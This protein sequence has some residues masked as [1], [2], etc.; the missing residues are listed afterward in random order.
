MSDIEAS[1][2]MEKWQPAVSRPTV[3]YELP[4]N[5]TLPAEEETPIRLAEEGQH[6]AQGGTLTVS[7]ALSIATFHLLNRPSTL[8]TLR[9]ELFGAIA[10]PD[11]AV[12]LA[13][14]ENLPYLRAVVKE[15]LRLAIGTSKLA[16]ISTDEAP[17]CRDPEA[18]QEWNRKSGTVV[19][20]S[21]Y[22]TVMDNS[23]FPDP[24]GFRPERWLADGAEDLDKYLVVFG[25]GSRH[26][27]DQFLAYAELYLM[28]AK[29]F[30]R[31]GSAGVVGGSDEGDRR[32]GDVGVFKI[33]ETTTTDCETASDYFIPTPYKV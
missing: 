30:R 7:W 20:M 29:L 2:D 23:I 13:Q 19:S 11:E 16:R 18:G 6:P 26:G 9:D 15:S 4:S 27:L 24:K 21:P 12:S 31:W 28:L 33:Y 5:K 22:L 32:S 25:S 14:L 8:Q 10:D 17:V 1:E 3:F